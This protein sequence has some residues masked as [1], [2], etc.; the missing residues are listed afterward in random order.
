[1]NALVTGG[2]EHPSA[3]DDALSHA[4]AMVAVPAVLGL[5]RLRGSTVALGTGPCF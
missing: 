4:M 5:A 2:G 3:D 1:M